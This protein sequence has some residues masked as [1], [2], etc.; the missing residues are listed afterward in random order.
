MIELCRR[1]GRNSVATPDAPDFPFCESCW[2]IVS[3]RGN[4]LDDEDG[5]FDRFMTEAEVEASY[6]QAGDAALA[7]AGEEGWTTQGSPTRP[8]GV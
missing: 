3:C 8:S 1:C 6:R 2:P 4:Y 5:N 7:T